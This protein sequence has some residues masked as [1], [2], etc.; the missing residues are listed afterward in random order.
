MNQLATNKKTPF[1]NILKENSQLNLQAIEIWRNNKGLLV[2]LSSPSFQQNNYNIEV[3][4]KSLRIAVK[5]CNAVKVNTVL[6]PYQQFT[7]IEEVIYQ[8]QK[9][10]IQL[11]KKQE[12]TIN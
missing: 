8:D 7:K 10:Q 3:K 2:T 5:H 1:S 12:T 6:L 11:G 4:D 9:L